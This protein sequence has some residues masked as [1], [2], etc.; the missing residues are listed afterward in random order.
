MPETLQGP[1]LITDVTGISDLTPGRALA[2]IYQQAL[3]REDGQV[4][5]DIAALALIY[6]AFLSPMFVPFE[7][8]VGSVGT[9][10]HL[11]YIKSTDL[12]GG[13][14]TIEVLR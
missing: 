4:Q 14:M 1:R 12:P 13:R 2:Q 10:E 6:A 5:K 11:G 9:L 8:E 7:I 3:T